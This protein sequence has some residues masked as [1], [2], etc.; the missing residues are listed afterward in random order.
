MQNRE[1]VQNVW[2]SLRQHVGTP[3]NKVMYYTEYAKKE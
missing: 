3:M 2:F 1:T